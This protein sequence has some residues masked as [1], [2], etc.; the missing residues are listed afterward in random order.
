MAVKRLQ[1]PN[2]R[3]FLLYYNMME[4]QRQ[5]FLQNDPSLQTLE[6]FYP[7]FINNSDDIWLQKIVDAMTSTPAGK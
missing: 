5:A 1:Q 4:D 6:L 3:L 2:K 7:V